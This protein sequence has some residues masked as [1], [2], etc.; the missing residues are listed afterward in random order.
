MRGSFF[1]VLWF[2]YSSVDHTIKRLYKGFIAVAGGIPSTEVKQ[3]N[4]SCFLKTAVEMVTG[5]TV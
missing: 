1:L 3:K 2:L 4:Q 5:L